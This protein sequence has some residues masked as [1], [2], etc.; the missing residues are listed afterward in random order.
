MDYSG[1]GFEWGTIDLETI[2]AT[3][4]EC[5]TCDEVYPATDDF[6]YTRKTSN[7][8]DFKTICKFCTDV[9]NRKNKLKTFGLDEWSFNQE[10][11]KRDGKCDICAQPCA[12]GTSLCIDYNHKTGKR[13][14]FLCRTCNSALGL[15][16]DSPDLL[17]RAAEY[18]EEHT[19]V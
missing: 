8:R 7:G 9:R 14:G 6:F 18:L 1:E 17:R 16:K 15:Y 13:R 5:A 3:F 19:D 2:S 11:K 12:S 4:K 10:I